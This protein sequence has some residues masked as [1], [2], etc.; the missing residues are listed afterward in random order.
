[1]RSNPLS[2]ASVGNVRP[3]ARTNNATSGA[4]IVPMLT[5]AERRRARDNAATLF[6]LAFPHTSMRA[7]A[8]WLEIQ[9]GTSARTWERTAG[10]QRDT[11][12][13]EMTYLASLAIAARADR[14]HVSRLM[15]VPE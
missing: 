11:W 5:P 2:A 4:I 3:H 7:A 15:G 6:R 14:E 12:H 13:C 10:R 1:M 9:T 8:E